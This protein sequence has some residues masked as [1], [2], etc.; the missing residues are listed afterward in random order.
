MKKTD[1]PKGNAAR[2]KPEVVQEPKPKKGALVF[3]RC[4]KN[5]PM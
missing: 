3:L 4:W 1:T 5:M 2:V